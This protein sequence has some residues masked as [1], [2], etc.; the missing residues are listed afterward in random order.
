M[1]LDKKKIFSYLNKNFLFE[2]NPII[3]VAVS[4]GPDS[5]ALIYLMKEWIRSK[6]G[7]IIALL[8]D[9]KL[10][11]ES[12]NECKQT[13]SYLKTLDVNS[14][15][16]VNRSAIKTDSIKIQKIIDQFKESKK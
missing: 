3:A 12:Y 13:Q 14:K 5:M 4:G 15:I 1:K 11:V 9:H 2:N 16:I 8:V 10:R 7:K 6:N